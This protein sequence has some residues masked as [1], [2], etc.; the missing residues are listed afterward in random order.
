MIAYL[1]IGFVAYFG[2]V[3]VIAALCNA[4]ARADAAADRLDLREG[5]GA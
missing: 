1:F 5:R 3:W 2:A 4:A